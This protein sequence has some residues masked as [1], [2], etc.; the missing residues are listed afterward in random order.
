M[1]QPFAPGG[2][3]GLLRFVTLQLTLGLTLLSVL[4]YTP[5]VLGLPIVGLVLLWVGV[6]IEVSLTYG[7]TFAFSMSIG[8]VIGAAG[9]HRAGKPELIRSI[10]FMPF[11][12]TLL[13]GPALRAFKELR[14][15]RFHWHKTRHG[16]SRIANELDTVNPELPKIFHQYKKE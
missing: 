1:T 14:G 13:F 15:Q 5:V 2:I 10:A 16:V 6:P 9:A 8:C 11:Y 4:F 3:R 12:W 7:L